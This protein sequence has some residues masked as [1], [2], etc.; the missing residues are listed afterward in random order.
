MSLGQA[1]RNVVRIGKKL[2]ARYE[3][4]SCTTAD[5]AKKQKAAASTG[6]LVGASVLDLLWNSGKAAVVGTGARAAASP[7]VVVGGI[8]FL[9]V[10]WMNPIEAG[11]SEED[12]KKAQK[13]WEEAEKS[14]G[15]SEDELP[16][17][18]TVKGDVKGAPSVDAGKQG[19]HVPGH[20]NNNKNKSQ[21]P[22]GKTGVK[23][24]Q[25]GWQKGTELP[26]GTKVWDS[27]KP[28]GPNG[29]TGVRVHIDGKG[30]IH[31][32]PVNPGQ[33]LK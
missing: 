18:S 31:G 24:T 8:V 3:K 27:G 30:N 5:K 26:D 21:W 1:A 6:T 11:E 32:Y 9:T 28:I 23:E 4:K 29:E 10:W 12:V 16:N 7:Y 17:Q 15:A 14:K 33:Y 2:V 25:E 22:E 13:K 19:K 20:N